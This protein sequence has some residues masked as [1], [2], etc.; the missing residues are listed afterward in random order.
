VCGFGLE[1]YDAEVVR[2]SPW[3]TELA[4]VNR[5]HPQFSEQNWAET[6][7]YLFSVPRRDLGMRGREVEA[8]TEPQRVRRH[9]GHGDAFFAQ[10]RDAP[11]ISLNFG[12]PNGEPTAADGEPRRTTSGHRSRCSEAY[13]ATVGDAWQR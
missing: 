6:Q 2:N 13:G 8:W 3:I 5:V 11:P 10:R 12:E 9:R 7:H 4:D 1:G